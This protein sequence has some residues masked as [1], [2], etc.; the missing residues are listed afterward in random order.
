M[1]GYTQGIKEE[2]Y[3]DLNLEMREYK[4]CLDF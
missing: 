3:E 1:T 4:I 2:K